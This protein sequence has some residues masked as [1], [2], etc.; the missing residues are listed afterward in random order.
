LRLHGLGGF[1]Q[2]GDQLFVLGGLLPLGVHHRLRGPGDELLVG[3][4]LLDAPQAVLGF[5]DLLA[6]PLQLR[7]DVHQ[8]AEG[9]IGRGVVGDGGHH[10]GHIRR[11][12]VRELHL[13]GISQPLDEV[14][15]LG[16]DVRGGGD[17]QHLRLPGRG[18]VHLRPAGPDGLDGVHDGLHCGFFLWE[19]QVRPV[20]RPPGG[21]DELFLVGQGLIDLLRDERHE[22][23]QQLQKLRQHKAEHILGRQL[24]PLVLSLEAGLG[25]LDIPVAVGIPQEVVDLGGGHADLVGVQV[26]RDLLHQGVQLGEDPLVLR[27]QGVRRREFTLVDGEVHHHEPAGV[28]DLVGEVPHGLALLGVEPGVVARGVA[29]DEV[30]A[31][32]V[33]AILLRHLQRID[34]VAQGLGHLAALVVPHQTVDQHGV[35]GDLVHLLTAGEDHPGH[36]EEDD[37]VTGD[38]DAGGIVEVQIS[39]LFRPAQSGERPQGAGEPGVQHVRV[40]GQMGEAALFALGGVLPGDVDV[41]AVVAGPGG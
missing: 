13:T 16:V 35:E 4:L 9:Q 27:R 32:R 29:G 25:E 36:P 31:Q 33:G 8:L 26:L 41:A 38:H 40:P 20:L 5:L 12:G 28:P 15:A 22:G 1:L 23:V 18:H 17:D 2:L 37:V 30:E 24:G 10:A 11:G 6:D 7:G 3:E 34:A 14:P 19:G 21:H 39:G